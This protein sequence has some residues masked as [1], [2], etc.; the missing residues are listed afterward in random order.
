MKAPLMIGIA[1]GTGSGK[2]TVARKVMAGLPEG[3][4]S[5]IEHDSYYRDRSD[6]PFEERHLLNYDHPESLDN[7]L[8][9]AHLTTL[10]QGQ[11]IEVPIYNYKRHERSR[12]T[13]HLEPTPVILIEGILV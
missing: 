13:K 12:D 2:T 4:V 1:G 8:L 7:E 11:A 6:V 9:I 3:T 5:L 10:R